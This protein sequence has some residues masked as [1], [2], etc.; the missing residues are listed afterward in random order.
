MFTS[1]ILRIL[2]IRCGL[3]AVYVYLKPVSD[4]CLMN[5][6]IYAFCAGNG[7]LPPVVDISTVNKVVEDV[8]GVRNNAKPYKLSKRHRTLSVEPSAGASI[9]V[10]V[11]INFIY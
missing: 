3:A 11:I 10:K 8:L 4:S 9:Y 7:H 2:D 6:M 5:T 1:S